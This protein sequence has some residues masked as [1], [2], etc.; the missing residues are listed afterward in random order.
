M[1][2]QLTQT[3]KG[4]TLVDS[5][6]L[7]LTPD[8]SEMLPRLRAD[9]LGHELLVRAARIRG[10]EAPLA[11]DATAGL[12]QDSLLLAAAGFRVVLFESDPTIFS[13]LADS[14]ERAAGD[15]A[16]AEA[17]LRMEAR[18][19]DSV[20]ALRCLDEV[21][22]VVYLDPMFPARTKSAAVKKKFQL[23]HELER[24][25]GN[26]A[27]LLS[28]ARAAHPRKIVVKRPAKGPYLAGEKP[29][30]SLG[31]KAVRYDVYALP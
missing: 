5:G 8:L 10:A 12:G 3:E 14:L 9:R 25:C 13:L 6:G 29:S 2:V 28:A 24:P 20:T 17:V 22:D 30:Y 15:P 1:G 18:Q 11:V 16:L 21:P 31:G 19:E 27:E 7:A 23:L 26:E 4:L